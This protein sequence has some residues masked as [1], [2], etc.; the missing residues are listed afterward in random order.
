[1]NPDH[2]PE[3]TRLKQTAPA[4]RLRWSAATVRSIGCADLIDMYEGIASSPD[5]E[6]K[7]LVA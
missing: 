7:R 5:G 2:K 3:V 6:V 1:L 4:K